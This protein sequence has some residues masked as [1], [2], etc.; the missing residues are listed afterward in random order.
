MKLR[1]YT[2]W[3][4][5]QKKPPRTQSSLRKR[6]FFACFAFSAVSSDRRQIPAAGARSISSS[7]FWPCRRFSA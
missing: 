4:H 1:D 6:F 3:R 5:D 2:G 7:A